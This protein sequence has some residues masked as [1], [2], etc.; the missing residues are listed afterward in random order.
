M[1]L[2]SVIPLLLL[3]LALQVKEGDKAHSKVAS[4]KD[5]RSAA[6]PTALTLALSLTLTP[7]PSPSRMHS[8][9]AG[10]EPNPYPWPRHQPPGSPPQPPP[11]QP[12]V[13]VRRERAR[14]GQLVQYKPRVGDAEV[15]PWGEGLPWP[16]AWSCW[17]A[18]KMPIGLHSRCPLGCTQDAHWA[19]LMAPLGCTHGT[20]G[21]RAAALMAP[22]D[23]LMAPL[24]CTYGTIGLHSWHHWAALMASRVVA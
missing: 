12:H 24:G 6:R 10:P 16:H 15:C 9:D 23:A 14:L 22:L 3:P 7:N 21:C 11:R 5:W 17:V 13:V 8:S 2:Y 20:S 19:A 4:L 18:L 1:E